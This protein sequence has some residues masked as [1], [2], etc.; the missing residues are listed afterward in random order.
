MP[1]CSHVWLL[2]DS[3]PEALPVCTSCGQAPTASPS[4]VE[5]WRDCRRK[6]A[7]SR[8][9]RRGP[10]KAADYGERCHAIA[11]AWLRDGTPPDTRTP[12]GRTVLAGIHLLPSPGAPGLLI[13][14]RATPVLHGIGWDMRLDYLFGFVADSHVI[15]GDHKTTGNIA[16]LA[17][18]AELLATTDPQGVAYS[19]WAAEEFQVPNVV[20]QWTY[21]QRDTKAPAKPVVFTV[22]RAA[23]A[24]RFAAMHRDEVL[25]MVRARAA[26]IESLPRS[27]DACSKYGGCPYQAE[28]LVGISPQ[29]RADAAL[30]RLR[31]A[32]PMTTPLPADLLAAIIVAGG[33]VPPAAAAVPLDPAV[34][35][36]LAAMPPEEAAKIRAAMAA[37]AAA[38]VA[39]QVPVVPPPAVEPVVAPKKTRKKATVEPLAVEPPAVEPPTVEPAATAADVPG[40]STSSLVPDPEAPLVIVSLESIRAQVLAEIAKCLTAERY[41]NVSTL[42]GTYATLGGVS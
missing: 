38:P 2:V 39:P 9:R 12:E 14:H 4:Q 16:E 11:E 5:T 25:P 7:Y 40:D 31:K 28:C 24:E 33:Q 10:N 23:V 42:A 29:E 21:Y 3:S 27:L 8:V 35:E 1:R 19:H 20:G 41:E 6:W 26:P 15:I 36:C 18:A 34:E 22:A 37:A 30:S 13:E 32:T 17:K